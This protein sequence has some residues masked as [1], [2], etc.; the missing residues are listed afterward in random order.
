VKER[1]FRIKGLTRLQSIA[2]YVFLGLFL[3][4]TVLFIFESPAANRVAYWGLVVILGLTLVKIIILSEQFRT[5]RLYRFWL[6]S[7]L[8]V[9]LILSTAL[10]KAYFI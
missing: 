8:L 10:L 1:Y 5:A 9:V 3:T 7:Y 6:L 4:A 2:W